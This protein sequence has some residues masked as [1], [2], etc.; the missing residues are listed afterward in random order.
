MSK[1]KKSQEPKDASKLMEDSFGLDKHIKPKAS[2]LGDEDLGDGTFAKKVRI[3]RNAK[4]DIVNLR[5]FDS[6]LTAF[7]EKSCTRCL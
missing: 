2:D 1:K 6:P 3:E 5:D 7:E 4:G